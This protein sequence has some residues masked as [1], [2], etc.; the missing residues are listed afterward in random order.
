MGLEGVSCLRLE[1]LEPDEF[2][3]SAGARD[4][5]AYIFFVN[6]VAVAVCVHGTSRKYSTRRVVSN[7]R[8]AVI[9]TSDHQK[10]TRLRL[11]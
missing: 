1:M 6:H 11:L 4:I 5:E 7:L 2:N 8:R 10:H 9:G 3:F